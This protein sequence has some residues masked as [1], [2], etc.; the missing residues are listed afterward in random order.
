MEWFWKAK[1]KHEFT[2]AEAERA[3]AEFRSVYFITTEEQRKMI[4][5]G[6]TL[7]PGEVI[8]DEPVLFMAFLLRLVRMLDNG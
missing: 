8:P 4:A 3:E 6:Y 1:P 7:K 5:L 2:R